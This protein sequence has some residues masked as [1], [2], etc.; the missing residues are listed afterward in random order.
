[1]LLSGA[2][3]RDLMAVTAASIRLGWREGEGK[4]GRAKMYNGYKSNEKSTVQDYTRVYYIRKC[5]STL[6]VVSPHA[7]PPSKYKVFKAFSTN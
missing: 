5:C 7:A 2:V 1:M 6:Y 3:R 4:G